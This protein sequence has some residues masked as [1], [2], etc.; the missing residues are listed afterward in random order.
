[1]N[2]EYYSIVKLKKQLI[3]IFNKYLDANDYQLFFFGSRVKGDN[4]PRADIDLGVEG[5]SK[6]TPE[7]KFKILD[8]LERL[9][10]LHKI[11]LVD[12]QNVSSEFKKEATKH[13][14]YVK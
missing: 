13:L 10:L 2:L 1:M 4:F 11:D 5:K 3:S 8:E 14:E 12:F 9:P 6:L 7:V